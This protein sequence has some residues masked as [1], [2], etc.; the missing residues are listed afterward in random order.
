QV[1]DA[2]AEPVSGQPVPA[3]DDQPRRGGQPQLGAGRTAAEHR[4]G[5]QPAAPAWQLFASHGEGVRPMAAAQIA[6]QWEART[7][8]GE[9]KKGVMEAESEEAV[10]N[11]LK[12]Q[13]LQPVLVKKQPKQ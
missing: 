12:L 7:R 10:H 5:R 2:D 8:S 4:V 11:K 1:G 9:T 6:F 3:P 13:L